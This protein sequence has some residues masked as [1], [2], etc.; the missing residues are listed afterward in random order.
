ML[1]LEHLRPG[2]VVAINL[3]DKYG[4]KLMMKLKKNHSYLLITVNINLQI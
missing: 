4:L 2:S 3:D 1:F